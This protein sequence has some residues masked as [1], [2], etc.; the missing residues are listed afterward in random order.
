MRSSSLKHSLHAVE[1]TEH[2]RAGS[3]FA[4]VHD[5]GSLWRACREISDFLALR[6]RRSGDPFCE[7]LMGVWIDPD[8]TPQATARLHEEAPPAFGRLGVM[9]QSISL[10]AIWTL[11]CQMGGPAC[12]VSLIDGLIEVS[13][14]NLAAARFVPVFRSDLSSAQI[15]LEMRQ[16]HQRAPDLVASPVYQDRDTGRIVLPADYAS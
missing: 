3:M 10:G 11:C 5:P 7:P 14:S 6:H 16:L 1:K 15:D 12:R 8:T 13:S 9:T 4:V 2:G